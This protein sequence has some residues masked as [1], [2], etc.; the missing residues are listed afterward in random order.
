[1]NLHF[2][3][4]VLNYICHLPKCVKRSSESLPNTGRAAVILS[5]LWGLIP[6]YDVALRKASQDQR[7]RS[8]CCLSGSMVPVRTSEIGSIFAA[9]SEPTVERKIL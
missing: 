6:T 4:E 5:G 7:R 1:M 8:G 2:A 9:I 3:Q